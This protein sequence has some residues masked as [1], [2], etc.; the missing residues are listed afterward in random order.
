MIALVKGSAMS[1]SRPTTGK[2]VKDLLFKLMEVG[3][4]CNSSVHS[5]IGVLLNDGLS[6]RKPKVV[7]CCAGIVLETARSFG[8]S[9]LPLGIVSSSIPKMLSHSNSVLRET[10]INI[11]AEICRALASKDPMKSVID[12]MKP[13]QVSQLDNLLKAQPNATMP[14]IVLRC[15][16]GVANVSS[17]HDVLAAFEASA[18]AEK[19]K[20]FES[21][22]EVNIFTELSKTEYKVKMKLP[23]WSDKFAALKIVLRCGGEKPYKLV[24]PSSDAPYNILICD[25]KLMLG[26]THF[27][28]NSN[29]MDVLGMIASGVKEKVFPLMKP[30]IA[31]L[32]DMSKDKKVH[33]AANRCLDDFYGNVFSL[34]TLLEDEFLP[35]S[36]NEQKQ[37]NPI[38]R[39][40]ALSYLFRS[41][42]KSFDEK[43]DILSL[44]CFEKI[45]ELCRTKLSDTDPAP[46]KLATE[47]LQYLLENEN[48]DA[49]SAAGKVL[50]EIKVS[51]PRAYKVLVRSGKSEKKVNKASMPKAASQSSTDSIIK[52]EKNERPR[53]ISKKASVDKVSAEDHESVSSSPSLKD[54]LTK[55]EGLNMK[56]WSNAEDEGG[57]KSGI[58]C[59]LILCIKFCS[60]L[61]LF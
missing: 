14:S 53:I 5:V 11:T 42:K 38:A 43:S 49:Q 41:M 19:A 17:P 2:L 26:H 18:M 60:I 29:A 48:K 34:P 35:E 13:A 56:N 37:K 59:K 45:S 31:L 24:P 28:V 47:I 16:Q 22:P 32:I 3:A 57:I 10:G 30:Y 27:A 39:T 46:R 1:S 9:C 15:N 4:T 40:T 20:L 51:H 52:L 25:L 12:D 6:S 44:E 54:A 36:L 61:G 21:R 7:L 50:Q 33:A 58:Q 23:K 8:A 55:L